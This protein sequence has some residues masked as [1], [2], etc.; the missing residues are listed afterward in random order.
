[1]NKDLEIFRQFAK[2][3]NK[4]T[5]DGKTQAVIYTRVS[6]KEQAENNASLSTKKSTVI[7]MQRREN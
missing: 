6:T 5:A 3:G 4:P 7:F 2:G 1:M